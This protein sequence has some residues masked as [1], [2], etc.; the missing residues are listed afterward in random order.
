MIRGLKPFGSINTVEEFRKHY[1]PNLI[2]FLYFCIFG[3]LTRAGA[4]KV[5]AEEVVEALTGYR[6]AIEDGGKDPKT[7]YHYFLAMAKQEMDFWLLD[8]DDAEMHMRML[9]MYAK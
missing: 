9:F 8:H 4:D 7:Y 6:T 1:P 5:D 2:A 3:V